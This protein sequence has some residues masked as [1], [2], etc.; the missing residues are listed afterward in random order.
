MAYRVFWHPDAE[1]Q[2][3][4]ILKSR[5]NRDK[6]AA[7]ARAIDS[8]LAKEPLSFG[9]SRDLGVRIGL[10]KPLGV[11][12]EVQKDVSTVIVYE[13]WRTDLRRR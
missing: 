6:L 2:L 1:L 13:V 10:M 3:E 9:E 7:A 12:F 11:I 4:R 5:L 8:R